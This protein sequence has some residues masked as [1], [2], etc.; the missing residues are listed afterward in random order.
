[1][2]CRV[3]VDRCHVDRLRADERPREKHTDAQ[4]SEE[5]PVIARNT[6]QT[7]L[8]NVPSPSQ[9]KLQSVYSKTTAFTDMRHRCF[10]AMHYA[11]ALQPAYYFC[12]RHG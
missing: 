1:M 12:A 4:R 3:C 7:I 6:S 11:R 8:S 5:V 9:Q 2:Y 10:S